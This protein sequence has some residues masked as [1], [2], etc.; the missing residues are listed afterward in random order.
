MAAA[1]AIA[2]K[3]N[4]NAKVVELTGIMGVSIAQER[5]SGFH[6]GLERYSGLKLVASQTAIFNRSEA[7][8]VME[9]II[10]STGGDFNAVYAHNDQMA[11]GALQAIK[12]ANLSN[13]AIVGIDGQAE[14]FEA[15]RR[16]EMYATITH[17]PFYGEML[18]ECIYKHMNG[19]EVPIRI[20]RQEFV[21]TSEN[22]DEMSHYEL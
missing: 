17:N 20:I 12:A 15:V 3:F 13:I 19:I 5:Y 8:K 6:E 9:N 4:G 21:I 18:Y 14:A 16:G 10:Q 2:D 22:A 1:A 7:Q 11:L